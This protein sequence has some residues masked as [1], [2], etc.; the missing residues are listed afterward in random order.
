MKHPTH[1]WLDDKTLELP[2]P[3]TIAI[4]QWLG[5]YE[6]SKS[7]Y[8]SYKS[9]I[10]KL[11]S[12]L[13]LHNKDIQDLTDED[14]AKF[15]DKPYATQHAKMILAYLKEQGILEHFELLELVCH[16]DEKNPHYHLTFSAYDSLSKD[17]A[18]NDFFSPIMEVI[19]ESMFVNSL[20]RNLASS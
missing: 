18:Y 2:E 15:H 19:L 10:N 8:I 1:N 5:S 14:L 7:T 6:Y 9:A 16:N 17:W 20:L 3:F 11:L 4:R 13:Q 12:F